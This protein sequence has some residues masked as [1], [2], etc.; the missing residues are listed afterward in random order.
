MMATAL[1]RAIL[2][3]GSLIVAVIGPA[4]GEPCPG[5]LGLT[6]RVSVP[7]AHD[8]ASHA[9]AAACPRGMAACWSHCPQTPPAAFTPIRSV[10]ASRV[11]VIREIVGSEQD[12]PDRH[13]PPPK[14]FSRSPITLNANGEDTCP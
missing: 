9:P 6:T 3:V 8:R 13:L 2:L 1:L 10:A 12:N 5:S 14:S 7:C 11:P 4:A